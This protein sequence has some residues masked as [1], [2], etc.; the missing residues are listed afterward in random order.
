MHFLLTNTFFAVLF[1]D[2]RSYRKLNEMYGELRQVHKRLESDLLG[3]NI[4]N[5]VPVEESNHAPARDDRGQSASRNRRK[6]KHGTSRSDALGVHEASRHTFKERPRS[7]SISRSLHFPL[8]ES[9]S[10]QG[11][12]R[13]T[14]RSRFDLRLDSKPESPADESRPRRSRDQRSRSGAARRK[15]SSS[16]YTRQMMDPY[17]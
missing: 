8:L 12:A 17:E 9:R 1:N 4:E 13:L 3:T 14:S 16:R 5:P 2:A 10:G 6:S 15:G 11:D 7:T